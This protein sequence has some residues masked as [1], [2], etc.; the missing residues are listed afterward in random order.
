MLPWRNFPHSALVRL[1]RARGLVDLRPAVP[2]AAADRGTEGN[3]LSASRLIEILYAARGQR[4]TSRGWCGYPAELPRDPPCR[5]RAR[6]TPR[7]NGNP[8]TRLR[9]LSPVPSGAV[10]SHAT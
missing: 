5:N 6:L 9:A 2:G 1:W 10:L 7:A 3:L 8:R 4:A